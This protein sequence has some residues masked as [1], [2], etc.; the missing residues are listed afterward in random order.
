MT[1]KKHAS[2][3]HKVHKTHKKITDPVLVVVCPR[4]GSFPGHRCVNTSDEFITR[5]GERIEQKKGS[6]RNKP[7]SDRIRLSLVSLS[8]EDKH[9]ILEKV[10]SVFENTPEIKAKKAKEKLTPEQKE[11]VEIL[12]DKIE[13]LGRHAEFVGPVTV[14]PILSVYR[15]LPIRKTK[16]A[17]LEQMA[18]DFAV[19]LGERIGRERIVVKRMPGESAVGVFVPNRERTMVLFRDTLQNVAAY[20]E[21]SINDKHRPIPLDMGIDINGEPVIDDL[22]MQPHLLIAGTTGGGKSTLLHSLVLA[23]TWTMNPRELKLIISDTKGVE[24]KAFK[25][26]PHL[27]RGVGSESGI[28]RSVYETMSAMAWCVKEAERRYK[29]IEQTNARN[30]HD[31]NLIDRE[32]QLPYIVLLVDELVDIMGPAL[33]R[34]EAKANSSKLSTIVARARACG[35]HVIAATQRSD[36]SLV[37][38]SIKANFPSRL[39]FRLPSQNDSRTILSTKGAENLMSRGDMF[40]SSS[41]SP[42]LRRLHAPYTSLEDVKLVIDMIVKREQEEMREL[43]KEVH[44]PVDPSEVFPRFLFVLELTFPWLSS[45]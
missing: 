26:L 42:E 24:F 5:N 32:H 21:E 20:A 35:I 8:K 22:T 7:H 45:L 16:V 11:I 13:V 3:K 38:G 17:Y 15:F 19:A 2:K 44:I 14:G 29:I 37:K 30:I 25:D 34:D 36:V 18:Q 9:K 1:K 31:Y 4:C 6:K 27:M 23:M 40:Y 10:S 12:S 28:C 39:C 43:E 41:T 33:D